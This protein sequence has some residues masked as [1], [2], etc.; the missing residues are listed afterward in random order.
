[1]DL[2][3]VK[4]LVDALLPE[5]SDLRTEATPFL[6]YR[7]KDVGAD[8]DDDDDD[9]EEVKADQNKRRRFNKTGLDETGAF[10]IA[11]DID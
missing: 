10:D 8:D 11:E 3:P 5:Y 4:H 2:G 9:D 1:M 7:L 6:S